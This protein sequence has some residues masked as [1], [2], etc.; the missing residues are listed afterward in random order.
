MDVLVRIKRLAIRG[1]IRYTVKALD[2][3]EADEIFPRDVVESIM[4]ATA[5]AKTLRSRNPARP[6]AKER[7]YVIKS[8][9]FDGTPI[10][11]KG[12]IEQEGGQEYFYVL[13]SAKVDTD[14]A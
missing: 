4:N 9:N 11:T 1:A 10:Y 5:I 8:P 12:K 6:D 2:E 7:L 13:I 14:L 3:M